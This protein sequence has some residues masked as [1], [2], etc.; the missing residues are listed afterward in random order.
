MSSDR[1][2]A[3]SS[4]G[5]NASVALAILCPIAMAFLVQYPGT[6]LYRLAVYP[7]GV[8]SALWAVWTIGRDGGILG[9]HGGKMG[10]LVGGPDLDS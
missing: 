6:K 8:I 10:S 1:P 7:V 3:G 5:E 2:A 9:R 4:S